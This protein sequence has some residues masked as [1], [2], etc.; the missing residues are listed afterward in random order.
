MGVLRRRSPNARLSRTRH[1]RVQRV[2]LE[3]HRDVAVAGRDAVDHAVADPRSRPPEIAS[4]PAS[5]RSA[6]VLPEP[7]GPTSTMNSPSAIVERELAH[8]LDVAEAL[9]HALEA[10]VRHASALH[11]SGEHAADE[12]AL[13]EDVDEHHRH[14]D[15]HRAGGEQREVGRVAALEEREPERRRRSPSSETITSARKNSFQVHMKISTTIVRTAGTRR[16]GTTTRHS[17]CQREAPSIRAASTSE[18]GTERKNARIQ[19]VPNAIDDADL[20]QDQRP[21]GVGQRR[22]RAKS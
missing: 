3:D 15:D 8:R 21:V 11:R 10:H 7:D 2:V 13:E 5:I 6:V 16:A 14:G 17:V 19:N 20:R 1:L 22:G 9:R 4:S 12:V 18:R